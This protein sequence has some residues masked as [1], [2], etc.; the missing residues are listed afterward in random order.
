MISPI[1]REPDITYLD[2]INLEYKMTPLLPSIVRTARYRLCPTAQQADL[3]AQF[4]GVARFVYNL[5]LEQRSEWHRQFRATT[6]SSIGFPSQCREL[7]ALRDEV[8]WIAAA[9]RCAL[10]QALRDLDTA[11]ARFFKGVGGYPSP[12][13]KGVN[14]S[15][16][17]PGKEIW[18]SIRV[19]ENARF[20]EIRIP[21]IG[22]CRFRLSRPMPAGVKL[23]QVTVSF[24]ALGW[25]VCLNLLS[26]AP[27]PLGLVDVIGIDRG[28]T[29]TLAFSDGIFASQPVAAMR[30]L[31]RRAKGHQKRMA[32]QVR[33]SSRRAATRRLFAKTKAKIARVRKHWNHEQTTRVARSYGTVVIEALKTSA[34]TR[35]AKGTVEAPGTNVRQKSGMNRSILEQGWHQFETLLAY[36]LD[37]AGGALI[38]VNPAYTSQTCSACGSISKDHRKSQA[39]FECSDCGHAAHADTNAAM[40]IKRAGEQPAWRGAVRPS[41]KRELGA[42][43]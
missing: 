32:R 13:R 41:T 42:V 3:L 12:R 43:A 18:S 24:D 16:R 28:V 14:D 38:K 35:S 37:T 33:G 1:D 40:N 9:P 2:D 23:L 11:F 36:K 5:G 22:W 17:I 31:Q 7:K 19:C 34:M 6:G 29:N 27:A 30:A 8:D 21:K 4:A 10:E 39:V 26:E 15:F 20:A 25:H